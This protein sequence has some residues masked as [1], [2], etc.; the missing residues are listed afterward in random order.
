MGEEWKEYLEKRLA[1]FKDEIM[2]QFHI[3][4]PSMQKIGRRKL[5]KDSVRNLNRRISF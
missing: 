1:N 5:S 4:S 2:H 3:I